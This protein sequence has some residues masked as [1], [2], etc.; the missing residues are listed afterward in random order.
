MSRGN[1]TMKKMILPAVI[2]AATL[3][4][5]AYAN[6]DVTNT[7]DWNLSGNVTLAS[8][9]R[10]RGISMTQNEPAIQGGLRVTHKSG[11]YAGVWASNTDVL[12]GASIEA[13]Y[14]LGYRH[15]LNDKSSLT[16][17]YI[18]INYPGATAPFDADF[19]EF[20]LAY[21][22]NSIFKANDSLTAS[23]A[24]S[25]DYYFESGEMYR[26]D[27]RYNF[28][29][30]ANF[31]VLLAGGMTQLEN[32][33]AFLKVWGSDKKDHYYDWKAG[34]SSNLFGVFSELYY[35]DNSTLNAAADSMDARV[36]FSVTKVF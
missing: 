2:T 24:Y 10:W 9:Y 16:V 35:A 1:K 36:V 14:M 25:N 13:D 34:L 29:I 20:S 6:E 33:Q 32:E 22:N 23:V 19:S 30:H 3:A 28:P 17:Q 8:D 26:L 21:N 7:P 15:A 4:T 11:A 12:N 27:A 31:G 5:V 18:D